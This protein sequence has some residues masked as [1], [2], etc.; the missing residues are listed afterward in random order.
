M[1]DLRRFQIDLTVEELGSIERLGALAGLRTKKE[2]TAT[3]LQQSSVA[4]GFS[5]PQVRTEYTLA[6][7]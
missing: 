4:R 2:V 3:M 5:I 6:C 7:R 1:S